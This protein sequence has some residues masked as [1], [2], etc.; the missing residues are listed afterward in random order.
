MDQVQL[1]HLAATDS[2]AGFE[3]PVRPEPYPLSY[4]QESVW[5]VEQVAPG[6]AA[7]NIPE[8]WLLKGRINPDLLQRSLDEIVRRHEVLR[9]VFQVREGKPEQIVLDDARLKLEVLD[10]PKG[11]EC[12][13]KLRIQ[14]DEHARQPFDLSRAPLARTLLFRLSAEEQV[15]FLNQHHLVSDGWSQG[16]FMAELAACY[17]A[18]VNNDECALSPLPVQYADFALWQREMVESEAGQRHFGYWRD[19]FRSLPQQLALPGDRLRTR[20]G[21]QEGQTQ[22]LDLSKDVVAP[23]NELSRQQGVTLYIT[24]LAAFKTLLH[25][26]TRQTDIVVGSPIACRDRVEVERLLGLFVHTHALRSDLSGD[27]TFL[28]VVRRVREV[29]LQAYEH[30]E[31]PGELLLKTLPI[32]RSTSGH[33]LFQVVFGWQ[34]TPPENWK[35]PAVEAT[36]I[37]LETGTAKFDWTVLVSDSRDG[38]RLRSE[39]S[40]DLC[41]P[42]TMTRILRQFQALLAE[43]TASP[44]SRISE[45]SL[46]TRTER[47]QVVVE[48]NRS[49]SVYERESRIHEVFEERAAETPE[50]IA[51]VFKGG[52]LTYAELNRDANQFARRLGAYGVT[53]GMRVGV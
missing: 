40:T 26:H 30:Q 34:N 13:E 45:F 33:P 19:R 37:D 10:L 53:A 7:Y 21:G 36:K 43:I 35:L 3:G 2:K 29:V 23:L 27:P 42:A 14:L 44:A 38:L 39:F 31:V 49:Q 48:W 5:F 46:L 47:D 11:G 41:E 8:A 32:E 15:L 1:N 6:T 24:L 4:A 17:T 50:A 16:L 12:T 20:K 28:E 18:F 22:F 9:T 51:L 25:R 52:S